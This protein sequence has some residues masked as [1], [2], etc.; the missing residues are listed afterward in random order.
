MVTISRDYGSG[1]DIIAERLA[2]RLGV[3]LFDDAI[4]KQIAVR[5]HEDPAAVR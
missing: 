4:L 2:Q 1:G 3:E 5:L